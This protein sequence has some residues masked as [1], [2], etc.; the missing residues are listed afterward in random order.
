MSRGSYKGAT[1]IPAISYEG[2]RAENVSPDPFFNFARTS[3]ADARRSNGVRFHRR[4]EKNHPRRSR[5][6]LGRFERFARLDRAHEWFSSADSFQDRRF[7]PFP[8]TLRYSPRRVGSARSYPLIFFNT[9]TISTAAS[10]ASEPLLP[11]L[12]PERLRACS[13]VSVV[14]TPKMIG[15]SV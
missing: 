3:P 4:A 15:T 5:S 11:D 9:L 14:S 1:D 6:D 2:T 12:R 7:D 8:L 13:T 10:A